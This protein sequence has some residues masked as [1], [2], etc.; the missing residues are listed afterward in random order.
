MLNSLNASGG[1]NFLLCCRF[2]FR[3]TS[4][5]IHCR[6]CGQVFCSTC[7]QDEILLYLD[8]Q[9]QAKWAVNGKEGGPKI[10]PER[11]ETLP[12]CCMCSEELQSVLLLDLSQPPAEVSDFASRLG[13]VQKKLTSFTT[14]IETWL[15]QYQQIV[16]SLDIEPG[17]PSSV[18]GRHPLRQLVK[19][20]SDLSDIFSRMAVHSQNLKKLQPQ[21]E[22]QERLVRYMMISTFQFYSENMYLFRTSKARLAELMPVDNMDEMQAIVNHQSMDKIYLLVQQLMYEAINLEK[23][24]KFNR[25]FFLQL[26]EVVKSI[27]AE[28]R[29]FLEKRGESWEKQ[30][31]FVREFV[32][33]EMKSGRRRIDIPRTLPR[34]HPKSAKYVQY[35]VV[36]KCSTVMHECLREL[37]AKTT[38]RSFTETKESMRQS[39]AEMDVLMASLIQELW[40]RRRNAA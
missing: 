3:M 25:D 20:Q 27:E 33:G 26:I 1:L 17:S 32:Q 14:K 22:S 4:R 13:E 2:Q 35:L 36:S 21:T 5:K 18:R 34:H 7:T 24:Y 11:Y 10:P 29:V 9:D 30:V 39:G 40:S 12:I 16:D 38:D 31:T 15:P 6:I 19:V 8:P 28:F 37:E 23:Q